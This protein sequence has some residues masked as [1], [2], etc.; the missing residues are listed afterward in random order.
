ME[1]DINLS[2][3]S[4][5]DVIFKFRDFADRWERHA[6]CQGAP[7]CVPRPSLFR[8]LADQLSKALADEVDNKEMDDLI[9]ELREKGRRAMIFAGQFTVMFSDHHRDP[10]LLNGL[11]LDI[12]TRT[13]HKA[14]HA[15]LPPVVSKFTVEDLRESGAILV[16][17]SGRP[18]IGSVEVQVTEGSPLDESSWKR[19]GN[20]YESRFEVKGL[21][22]VR[23]YYVRTRFDAPAGPGPW[24]QILT[25]VVS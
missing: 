7:D 5:G 8:E 20:F 16:K 23:K 4:H 21:E 19:V 6:A 15:A 24:S 18:R 12:K 10:N 13:Y 1:Y 17:V 9:T 2:G 11:G 3:M 25:I 14:D 22:P